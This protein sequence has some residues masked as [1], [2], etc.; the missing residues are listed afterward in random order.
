[1]SPTEIE[2]VLRAHPDKL[3]SDVSVAG[4][5]GGRKSD[6]KNPRAWLVLSDAGKQVGKEKAIQILDAWAKQNLS[7]YKWIRGGYET[8][9]QASY[10]LHGQ[11]P[12]LISGP[13]IDSKVS[14]GEGF[15]SCS[16]RNV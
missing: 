15:A 11:N 10:L 4:V 14:N 8:I 13:C 12:K 16:H 9:D 3:I 7:R 6:E 5:S 2:D 1:M